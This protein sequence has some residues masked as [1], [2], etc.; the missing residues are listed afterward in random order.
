MNIN[1]KSAGLAPADWL[2]SAVKNNPE[3][4]L[5]LAAGCALLFRTGSSRSGQWSHQYPGGQGE[6]G[7]YM[8]RRGSTGTD[9]HM[10]QGI[11]QV[12]DTVRAAADTASEYASTVG[13][14]V[15]ETA[16]GYASAAG[17][18]AEHA[19]RAIM[20]QSGRMAEQTQSTIERIVREQPLAVAI[21]GLAAGAAVAAAF[22]ATRLERETLGPAGKRLSEAASNAGERL[23]KAASAAG[24]RLMTVA[25]ERGV[26]ADGL[27][28]VARDVAGSF[29]KSLSGGQQDDRRSGG[30]QDAASSG[31]GAT[32][33]S[34]GSARAGSTATPGQSSSSTVGAG[35]RFDYPSGRR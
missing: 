3:G 17:E 23:G 32:Q 26:N 10:P 6:Q 28:E 34:G 8:Q 20:D 1:S 13:T 12:A 11:S 27:K 5:L 9:W 35:S 2:T 7:P 19:G 29:E 18:Y 15:G 22:P 14:T 21:A 25:E 31:I 30:K 4:L 33:P 16:R 24:E